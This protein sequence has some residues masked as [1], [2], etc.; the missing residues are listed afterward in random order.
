MNVSNED[1]K[2][3]HA[4]EGIWVVQIL[5]HAGDLYGHAPGD[6]VGMKA[7]LAQKLIAA[8]AAKFIRVTSTTGV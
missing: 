5:A 6:V 1:A 4:T 8:G 7:S 2:R 3:T